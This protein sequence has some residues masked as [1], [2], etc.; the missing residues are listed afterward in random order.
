MSPGGGPKPGQKRDLRGGMS[1]RRRILRREADRGRARAVAIAR[2]GGG[3]NTKAN[4]RIAVA[5]R[6]RLGDTTSGTARPGTER[7]QRCG[8]GD[9]RVGYPGAQI[10]EADRIATV[11]SYAALTDHDFELFIADLFGAEEGVRYEVFARGPDLG[12][13]L[14]HEDDDGRSTSCSA[15][16]SSIAPLRRSVRRRETRRQ[17]SHGSH[18]RPA[19]YRFV[20]SRRL[21]VGNKRA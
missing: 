9:G 8:E 16:T 14:R 10:V 2:G 1:R 4:M 11:H 17:S 20:T 21:T 7:R 15:S 13:D 5:G 18:P 3:R 19:S 12:V 6:P